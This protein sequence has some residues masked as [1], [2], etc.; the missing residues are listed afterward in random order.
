MLLTKQICTH[1]LIHL[2][3]SQL[4]LRAPRVLLKTFPAAP[5]P[6]PRSG[7]QHILA[8]VSDKGKSAVKNLKR[9]NVTVRLLE[10]F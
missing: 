6:E 4:Y 1:I 8:T 5:N 9:S 3:S 10:R 2:S 7:D